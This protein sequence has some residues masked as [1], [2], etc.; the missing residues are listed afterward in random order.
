MPGVKYLSRDGVKLAYMDTGTGNPALL[1]VHGWCCDNTYWREQVADFSKTNRVVA[2]DLR[3]HGSSDKPKQ[4][5]NMDVFAD[6]LVWLGG[7]LGLNRPVYVGHSMGG[8][9]GIRLG[10]RYPEFARALVLVDPAILGPRDRRAALEEAMRGPDPKAYAASVIGNFWVESTPQ[11]MRD[12]ITA[13]MLQAAE[14][15]MV[16]AIL[17]IFDF[18]HGAAI[19]ALEVPTYI[20]SAPRAGANHK[21]AL[22]L[23]PLVRLDIMEGVGHF[24]QLERP[25]EFNRCLR[26]F[27]SSLT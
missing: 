3:G 10:S 19:K 1:F 4:D 24:L 23:N 20:V 5:Y 26:E 27:V 16:P 14:H 11:A 15:V 21:A 2:V 22:D 25:D 17:S 18:D 12:E 8:A 13:K 6:D 7:Q 9:I